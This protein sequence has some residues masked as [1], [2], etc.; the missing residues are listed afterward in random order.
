MDVGGTS[1]KICVADEDLT[2]LDSK[3][4]DTDKS[5]DI[6]QFLMRTAQTFLQKYPMISCVSLGMPGVVDDKTGIISAA[7]SILIGERDV[8]R[9]LS[10]NLWLPVYVENDVACWA[11]AEGSIGICRNI[12]DYLFLTI[13]TGIGGCIVTGG[14]IYRGAHNAAGEIGYMVFMDDLNKKAKN[15]DEFGSLE[16]RAS[17]FAMARDYNKLIDGNLTVKEMY[18]RFADADPVSHQFASDRFN[19]LSVAIANTIV[20]LDPAIVVIAGGITNDWEYLSKQLVSR[21]NMLI[22]TKTEIHRSQTGTFGGALGAII[23]A[24]KC[25]EQEC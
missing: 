3:V 12:K 6:T 2:V 21:I 1:T 17:A 25:R 14:K 4:L 23:R 13:G 19:Y 9:E 24:K 15:H 22:N 7:P 10:E 18:Q 5:M 8:R 11:I 20:I 16:N